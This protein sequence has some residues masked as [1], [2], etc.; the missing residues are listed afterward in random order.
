M[1]VAQLAAGGGDVSPS[2]GAHV[3]VDAGGGQVMRLTDS[4][5]IDGLPAVSPDGAWVAFVSNRSG[6]WAVY[7]V[8]SGGGEAQQLFTIQGSWGNWLEQSLQWIP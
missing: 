5:A 6:G 3:G 8:P 4:G 7:A 2:A 1:L